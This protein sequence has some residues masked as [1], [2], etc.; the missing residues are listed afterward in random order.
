MS[1]VSRLVNIYPEVPAEVR[2]NNVNKVKFSITMNPLRLVGKFDMK[3]KPKIE[4]SNIF[5]R[6][7]H[8]VH[9]F[10]VIDYSNLKESM[11]SSR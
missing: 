9:Y 5:R 8:F 11:F 7:N 2:G 4:K 1:V 6:R 10:F 3:M